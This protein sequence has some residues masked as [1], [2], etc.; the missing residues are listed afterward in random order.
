MLE[1]Q[2]PGGNLGADEQRKGTRLRRV[3]RHAELARVRVEAPQRDEGSGR[4]LLGVRR[5]GGLGRVN[6]VGDGRSGR[7]VQDQLAQFALRRPDGDVMRAFDDARR[8]HVELGN[9]RIEDRLLAL[10]VAAARLPG[11]PGVVG[12]REHQRGDGV[13]AGGVAL[14]GNRLRRE[15][16]HVEIDDRE[17]EAVDEAERHRQGDAALGVLLGHRQLRIAP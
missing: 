11:D 3:E 8:G 7:H 13:A 1:G 2:R 5:R 10:D 16:V 12:G 15:H 6:H 9:L 17:I 14:D 4:A